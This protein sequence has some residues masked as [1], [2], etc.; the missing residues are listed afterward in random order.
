MKESYKAR[1]NIVALASIIVFIG[2]IAGFLNISGDVADNDK[3]LLCELI[4]LAYVIMFVI[5]AELPMYIRTPIGFALNIICFVRFCILPMLIIFD[6]SYLSFV[7]L[8]YGSANSAFYVS[9][10]LLMLWEEICIASYLKLRLPKWYRQEAAHVVLP[11]ESG[12]GKVSDMFLICAIVACTALVF[13]DTSILKKFNTIF[14]SA[15][16]TPSP[17]M[18]SGS[19]LYTIADIAVRCVYLLVPIPVISAIYRSSRKSENTATHYFWSMAIM[20]G[21]YG[22]IMEG[23]SR[24]SIIVPMLTVILVLN[25]LYPKQ[26]KKTVLVIGTLTLLVIVMTSALKF[27]ARYSAQGMNLNNV[28]MEIEVYFQ[29]IGNVGKAVAAKQ[30]SGI[31]MSFVVMLNDCLTSV[32]F[33]SKLVSPART[34]T[35][36]YSVV[37]QGRADQ[38]IPA[39]GNGLFYFGYL[40][41]PLVTVFQ[42]RVAREF[43]KAAYRSKSVAMLIVFT[44]S[45]IM[46]IYGCFSSI[47]IFFQKLVIICFPV[48]VICFLNEKLQNK[49]RY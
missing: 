2:L 13:L 44:Y 43:E 48:A 21:W 34:S 38:V 7:P 41:A 23:T 42:I 40:L 20:I 3:L 12:R 16:Y 45:A 1:V 8:G 18:V 10:S 33:L 14:A 39:V 36:W 31:G 27:S 30:T 46:L 17:T 49:N 24:A 25:V 19:I 22:L 9:G 4:I 28:I 5:I 47:S 32:P 15:N 26:Q 29:G 35:I 6:H 11:D 37:W